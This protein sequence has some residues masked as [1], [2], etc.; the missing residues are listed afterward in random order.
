MFIGDYLCKIDNKGRVVLPAAHRKVLMALQEDCVVLRKNLFVNCIDL[1]PKKEWQAETV[2]LQGSCSQFNRKQAQFLREYFRG[3]MEVELD[4]AGRILIPKPMMEVFGGQ[5]ELN[6]VAVGSHIE[7]WEKAQ[8]EAS[9]IPQDDL[10]GLA[11]E[12]YLK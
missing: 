5:T 4:S 7:I 2:S 6:V 3:A 10:A 12:L 11:D 9:R 8:Y 1:F